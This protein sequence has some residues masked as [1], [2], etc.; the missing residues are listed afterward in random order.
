MDFNSRLSRRSFLTGSLTVLC[1][2]LP[3]RVN[4]APAIQPFSFA[5]V[6]GSYL[7]NNPRDSHILYR[8]SLL[9]LQDAVKLI[10]AR[11]PDFIICGGN[12]VEGLGDGDTNWQLFLDVC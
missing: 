9:F 8:E 4:A 3:A 10:N 5:F 7:C 6:N 1:L 11:N 12:Q 2:K